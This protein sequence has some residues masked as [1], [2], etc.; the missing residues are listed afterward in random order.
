MNGLERRAAA[1]LAAQAKRGGWSEAALA[2]V[3]AALG[4]MTRE[5]AQKVADATGQD[6]DPNYTPM[7]PVGYHPAEGNV[8]RTKD[9]RIRCTA[10]STAEKQRRAARL[11]G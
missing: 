11:A 2:D 1:I 5:E 7:C 6:P 10:C 3:F 9:G 8:F 4:F